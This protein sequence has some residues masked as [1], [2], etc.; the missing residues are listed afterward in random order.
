[1]KTSPIKITRHYD[2]DTKAQL[3]ALECLMRSPPR[4]SGDGNIEAASDEHLQADIRG[5]EGS[6]DDSHTPA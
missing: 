4:E 5:Q 2:P 6:R 3:V 1:M